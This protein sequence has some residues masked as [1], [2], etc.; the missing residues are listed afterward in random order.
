MPNLIPLLPEIFMLSMIVFIILTDLILRSRFPTVTYV[1]SQLSLVGSFLITGY[2]Y[3]TAPITILSQGFILDPL[4][5]LLKIFIYISS[6]FVFWFSRQYVA[7]RKMPTVEYY[8]LSLFAILG[9]MLLVSAH[10]FIVL[11]LALELSALPVYAL[12]ALWNDS[13]YGSEASMKYFVMGALASGMLLYGL[14]MLYG[15][16]GSLEMIPV[17]QSPHDLLIIFALV[18]I[19]AGIAF[20]FGAAPFHSWVPDVYTGAP[21]AITLFIT[22]VPKLAALGLA[23]RLLVDTLPTLQPDWQHLLIII[24]I[25]SMALGNIAAIIQSNL[26][27][28]LSYSSIAH[29]GYMS[30]GLLAG[31]VAHGNAAALFYMF[32]YTLMAVG[33]FGLLTLLSQRGIEIENITDLRGLNSRN[34]WLAFMMLLIMFSMAGIPPT[35]GFFAKLWVLEAVIRIHLVWLATLALVFAIIGSYYY[36]NVVKV[37][38]FEEPDNI[39]AFE[40]KTNLKVALSMVGM[41]VLLLGIIPSSVIMLCRSVF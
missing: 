18:F 20:K 7:D 2:L 15:A 4:A 10:N 23:F 12:V 17:T 40:C 21:T 5:S 32:S 14:S 34:P 9:M 26:K 22:S 35:V 16:T 31:N 3:N 19:L 38:Y 11:F 33:A 41:T 30:L 29:M 24:A 13:P 1:L 27:R 39:Q 8:A 36:I 28:M 6:F 25:A 37:M